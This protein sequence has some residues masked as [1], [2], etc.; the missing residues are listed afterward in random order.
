MKHRV[1]VIGL[2]L[3]ALLVLVVAW[4]MYCPIHHRWKWVCAQ[5][6]E[7][8][9]SISNLGMALRLYE[10]D[11]GSYPERIADLVSNRTGLSAW[12]GPYITNG[13]TRDAWGNTFAYQA[14]LGNAT[15][16]YTL[17]SAGPD[18]EHGTQD[19]IR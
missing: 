7:T 13:M 6:A 4:G 18:G 16:L 11:H 2:G 9:A 5:Y 3:L 12:R 8:E 17:S 15:Q 10:I 1:A 14:V 19:D